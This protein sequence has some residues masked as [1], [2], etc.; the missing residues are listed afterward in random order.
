MGDFTVSLSPNSTSA[1]VGNMTSS[2]SILTSPQDGFTGTIN[3]ALQ[4]I[5]VGVNAMP[6]ANFSLDVGASQTVTF[7]LSDSASIGPSTIT[8]LATSG[9]LS[10][11]AQLTL[12]AE[13]SVRTYQV[14]S[15]LYL[16]SGSTT[17]IARVGLETNWG[18]S[19]VEVSLNGT[20]FV[21]RHDTGRE[22]QPSYRDGDNL[23]Y[24]PTLGGD[25]VD[26]GTPTITFTVAPDS[27]FV[28]AQPLQWYSELYGG[29]PGHPILGDVMVEQTVTAVTKERNTFKVHIKATHLR[30]DLHTI[31]GQE[32][33]AV[34]TNRDYNRFI[35]YSG[36]NPWTNGTTTVTMFPN[37]PAFNPSIYISERWG[38]LVNTQNQGLTVYV[39]SVN[40]S[41]TGFS[42]PGTG[43]SPMDDWTNYFAPLGNLSLTPGFVFEGDFYVIAGDCVAARQ[44][45]YRLHG[46]LTIP[47]IFAPFEATDQPASGAVVSG[48][49]TVSGWAFADMANVTKVEV[50]V[51]NLT[52][53]MASYGDA[54]PDVV[55]AYPDSPLNVGFS[56]S[57]NTTRY[58]D[59][60]H[61][62]YVRVTDSSGNV[63]IAPSVSVTFSNA[64]P[65]A[66]VSESE[67]PQRSGLAQKQSRERVR[68]SPLGAIHGVARRSAPGWEAAAP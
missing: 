57:L 5:P 4:G 21:N 29:G 33:P 9:K 7:A 46:E 40:P 18:G 25:D 19:I 32:F 13:A 17:D 52:D 30:N 14:G 11:S 68:P 55:L 67:F 31:T 10:H 34:Y 48:I 16:E 49:T 1:V 15:V 61:R 53:G 62:I 63:A 43:S 60:P 24:N 22:V 6:A 51:D 56:Y 23:T 8:I 12:T 50:L 41:M 54:R 65:L 26:Q 66:N 3:I 35:T 39:P 36:T 58:L 28:Q 44:T 59:G 64:A 27:L 45:I 42:A 2:V 47:V 37:L 20:N 38:A